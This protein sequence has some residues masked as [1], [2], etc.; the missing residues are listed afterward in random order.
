VPAPSASDQLTAHPGVRV[1]YPGPF[2]PLA[3][4]RA[5]ASEP[6]GTVVLIPGYTGAKEDF[7]PILGPLAAA[8]FTAVAVDLPGQYESPGSS[9]EDDY[10]PM[11]L[12]RTVSGLVTRIAADEPGPVLLLGH[13]FGGLVSRAAVLAGAPVAGLTLLCSGPAAFVTGNR[14]DALQA[15]EPIFRAEGKES[16][17]AYREALTVALRGAPRS[18][19]NEYFRR[20]F[21]ASSSAGLLGMARW[22]RTEPDRTAELA[23]TGVPVAVVSGRRDDAW[24]HADQARMARAL[25]TELVIVEDA[26]HSPAVENPAG[27]LDVLIPRWR[28]WL[29]G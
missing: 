10:A 17:F 16:V 27:L 1:S 9:V 13:S 29:A 19:L 26:A 18:E 28:S 8:G 6:T 21:L 25:G 5:R 3:A 12:G 15:A 23:A 11:T 2:G 7:A 22:L 20:R 24:P 14:L 4:L